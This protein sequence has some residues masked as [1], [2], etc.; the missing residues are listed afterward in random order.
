MSRN[1]EE[2]IKKR[3]CHSACLSMRISLARLPAGSWGPAQRVCVC[4]GVCVGVR[5]CVCECLFCV[6]KQSFTCINRPAMSVS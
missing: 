1:T 3:V 2:S 6:C 4:V 5:V